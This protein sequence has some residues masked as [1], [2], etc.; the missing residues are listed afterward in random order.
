MKSSTEM[1]AL[2]RIIAITLKFDPSFETIR[3]LVVEPKFT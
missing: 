1:G 2:K 3:K